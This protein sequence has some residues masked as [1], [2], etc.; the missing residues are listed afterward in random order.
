MLPAGASPHNSQGYYTARSL[1]IAGGCR[2]EDIPLKL[3]VAASSF[4]FNGGV[5]HYL[6]LL[7]N[8]IGLCT[9][10]KMKLTFVISSIVTFSMGDIKTR[11]AK[12]LIAMDLCTIVAHVVSLSAGDAWLNSIELSSRHMYLHDE[13]ASFG[14]HL[15]Q[16][17]FHLS[18]PHVNSCR[19]SR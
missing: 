10:G 16:R 8:T 6:H 19:C 14:R 15:G 17:P 4:D 2:L 11:T 3:C 7:F 1:Y 9:G 18:M 12:R 13:I 5:A